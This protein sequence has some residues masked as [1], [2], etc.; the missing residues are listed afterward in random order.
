[1]LARF[2][3]AGGAVLPS[4]FASDNS[5][6]LPIDGLGA[7]GL[8]GA[9]LAVGELVTTGGDDALPAVA[10]ADAG[11]GPKMLRNSNTH[12]RAAPGQVSEEAQQEVPRLHDFT[13]VT[14]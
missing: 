7:P 12:L 13:R 14:K 6:K 5:Q 10:K 9:N 2:A 4:A 11:G 8:G 1:M 3:T